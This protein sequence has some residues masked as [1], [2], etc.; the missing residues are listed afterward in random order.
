MLGDAAEEDPDVPIIT[1][2]DPPPA[3][4]VKVRLMA[5][6]KTFIVD[7]SVC[8]LVTAVVSGGDSTEKLE[9]VVFEFVD[10]AS[11]GLSFQ[12]LTPGRWSALSTENGLVGGKIFECF[13]PEPEAFEELRKL[14]AQA[15]GIAV[16]LEAEGT[17]PHTEVFPFEP[18]FYEGVLKLEGQFQ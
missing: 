9:E 16:T 1:D 7:T 10:D 17:E 14:D 13:R 5:P 15:L 18:G 2:L 12:Q 11:N 3:G 8:L 4:Q 6:P